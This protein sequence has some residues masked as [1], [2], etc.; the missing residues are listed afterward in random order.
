MY[1][2]PLHPELALV[3]MRSVA[4]HFCLILW[5]TLV[6]SWSHSLGSAKLACTRYDWEAGARFLGPSHQ[7][8]WCSHDVVSLL[9]RLYIGIPVFFIHFSLFN[10]SPPLTKSELHLQSLR[11]KVLNS[12]KPRTLR[13]PNFL[14]WTTL[15]L[16][17]KPENQFFIEKSTSCN[18]C[19][20]MCW[21]CIWCHEYSKKS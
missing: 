4:G 19:A 3:G 9:R 7:A 18:K 17:R 16:W 2:R 8:G 14:S 1:V 13:R 5:K 10:T 12:E 20:E 15:S 6:C 21:K 11:E